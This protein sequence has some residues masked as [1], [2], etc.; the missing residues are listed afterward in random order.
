MKIKVGFGY[1]VHQLAVGLPLWLGGVK[2][3]HAKGMVA[4][5][6]GDVLIHAICECACCAFRQVGS[7]A[8]LKSRPLQHRAKYGVKTDRPHAGAQRGPEAAPHPRCGM[9]RGA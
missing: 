2:F 6:D 3:E 8:W 4:H 9:Q 7:V 5:S 1:D